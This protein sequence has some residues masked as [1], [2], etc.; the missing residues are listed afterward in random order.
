MNNITEILAP[1][2]SPDALRAAV[3][4]G[5]D[6]VYLGVKE[7]NA[8]RSA[9]NFELENLKETVDFCHSRGVK[10][11]LTLNTLIGDS[12]LPTAVKI[13]ECSYTSGVDA[14]ILQDFA[15]V[16][17]V[18]KVAPEMAMHASTQMSVQTLDGIKALHE[19]GFCRAVLPR[20]MSRS[21]IEYLCKNSPIEL[22]MFVHGALCMCVSGQCYLSAM[23]GSRSGNRGACAQPCRLP[24]SAD[25]SGSYDL[26]LKDLSLTDEIRELSKMGIASFKIEGRMKRPEY[27]AAA[28]TACNQALLGKEDARLKENLKSVFSRTGFTDGYYKG[29]L[30]KEMFGTRRKEDVVSAAPVLNELSKLYEKEKPSKAVDFVFTVKL[31]KPVKL[32]ATCEG[33]TA[34]I[35]SEFI[36]RP[37]L[38]KALDEASAKEQL[39]KTGGTQYYVN[40]IN[41]TI[42][43]GVNVPVSV[44]NQ[45]RRGVLELLTE[46]II[47]LPKRETNKY[48]FQFNSHN[49]NSKK[50]ICRFRNEEQI[51]ENIDGI[52]EIILPVNSIK[53]LTNVSAEIPRGIFGNSEKILS[54]LLSLKSKGIK[55][56]WAGTFDGMVLAKKAGMSVTASFGSNIF[57]TTAL[58]FYEDFGVEKAL[59]SAEMTLARAKELGGR[60]PRGIFA[61]G[62][63]PLMLT[64]NCPV[65]NK[66]TCAQCKQQSVLTD[67]KNISFPVDCV[68]GCSELLNSKPV[69]MADRL[70]EIKNANFILLYF[71]TETKDEAAKIIEAYK[72][73]K[74][75]VGEFTRGLLYRG[76]E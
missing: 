9:E 10:V 36:T 45:L 72:K 47:S 28:V 31:E 57:N 24:F 46:K 41:C 19:A 75:P 7:L 66:K 65:K 2:G 67:R 39:S 59:L 73:G 42:D 37:A 12:E 20:E 63:V 76:V 56:A 30:G 4:C 68:S 5:A 11:Y 44:I 33:F 50:I 26:S 38:N 27:V 3:L 1:A 32:T 60:L 74:K 35:E 22:E 48:S 21:E 58:K 17:I 14:L 62:R 40:E 55:K 61:Y 18:K 23:L 52:D 70:N 13:I 53:N 16:D 43:D 49:T 25:N 69:Y 8:R 34:E 6:A 29:T 54:S 71:T 64:R 15:A 51:P